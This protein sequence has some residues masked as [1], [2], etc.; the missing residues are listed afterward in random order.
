MR[1]N[2]KNSPHLC[3]LLTLTQSAG[4]A[5]TSTYNV[6]M[7]T[8]PPIGHPAGPF[9]FYVAMTDG[10]GLSD[11]NNIITISN[12]DFGGGRALGNVATLGATSAT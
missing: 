12:L 3:V 1:L 11:G 7:N 2:P 8:A 9:T 5:R 4:A 6:S 10:S